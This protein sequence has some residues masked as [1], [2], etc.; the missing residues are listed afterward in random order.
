MCDTWPI[1]WGTL[2]MRCHGMISILPDDDHESDKWWE[3]TFPNSSVMGSRSALLAG[4]L[5]LRMPKILKNRR[6]AVSANIAILKTP[7]YRRRFLEFFRPWQ[8]MVGKVM[9]VA[10]LNNGSI[11]LNTAALR[12]EIKWAEEWRSVVP[13]LY[14]IFV[15]LYH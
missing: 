13:F 10:L 12:F 14:I 9:F 8:Q 3:T 7:D 11:S 2:R 1:L 6:T 4:Q 5:R 15:P